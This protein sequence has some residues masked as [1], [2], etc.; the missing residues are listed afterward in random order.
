[1][2]EDG[3]GDEEAVVKGTEGAVDL[4][5]TSGVKDAAGIVGRDAS[6][7]HDDDAAIGLKDELAKQCDP[8]FGSGCLSGGEETRTAQCDDVLEGLIGVA[9]MVEGAVEGDLHTLG[10]INETAAKRHVDVA[11]GGQCTDN[12]AIGTESVGEANVAE[13]RFCLGFVIG[14][15]AFARTDEDVEFQAIDTTST[16]DRFGRGSKP[17]KLEGRTEFD[18]LGTALSGCL[19]AGEVAGAY[20]EGSHGV[21]CGQTWPGRKQKGRGG[22]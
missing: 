10:G 11:I 3:V 18:T 17:V 13:H 14:K 16:L 2:D 4:S 5:G 15:I 21:I 12:Y 6:T 9:G 1:V 22:L 19:G 8:G 7:G 20:F